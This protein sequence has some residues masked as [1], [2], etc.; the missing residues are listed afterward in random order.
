[1]FS[2]AEA[3]V[4]DVWSGSTLL[5]GGFG[6]TGVP[7]NILLAL[8][9]KGIND[10]TVVSSNVGTAERGLGLLFQGKQISRMVGSYVGENEIFE[11]QYLR[12]EL[13]VELVPMGTLAERMRA[14]GAGIPA[15]YTATGVG[16][17]VHHGNM[18][19]RYASDGSG[20]MVVGSAGR[21]SE[22]FNGK[23]YI[24]EEAISGDFALVRAWKGD[25]EGNLVYR[26]TSRNHNP[27]VATAGRITIAEVEELVPAGTLD[28]DDVHTPGIYVDRIFQGPSEKFIERLTLAGEST[29]GAGLTPERERIARRAAL[30]LSDG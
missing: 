17:L 13:D 4:A 26:K 1:M 8:Q 20:R 2:S 29:A 5:V 14:A 25:T 19:V 3:A 23:R 30:E 9:K 6:L 12:G 27:A 10:L 22:V 7:E 24:M 11:Q 28:P 18:P 21:R 16:T 15:F